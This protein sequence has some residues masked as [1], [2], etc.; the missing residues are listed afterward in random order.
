[1]VNVFVLEHADDAGV[2]DSRCHD[3]KEVVDQ[4]RR[5]RKVE[6]ECLWKTLVQPK[7]CEVFSHSIV[8]LHVRDLH[9]NVSELRVIPG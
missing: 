3:R 6:C 8:D 4:K 1:M 5:F 2:I 9:H 7:L